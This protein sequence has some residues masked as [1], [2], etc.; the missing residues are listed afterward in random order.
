MP[1]TNVFNIDEVETMLRPKGISKTSIYRAISLGRLKA[2]RLGK[3]YLVSEQAL[4]DFLTGKNE[5]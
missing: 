2:V 1:V 5:E 4:N 3:R